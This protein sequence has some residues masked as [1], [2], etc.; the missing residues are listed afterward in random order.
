M[1]LTG[2]LCWSLPSKYTPDI[3]LSMVV[4]FWVAPLPDCIVDGLQLSMQQLSIKSSEWLLHMI[5]V[6]AWADGLTL[7]TD[8]KSFEVQTLCNT[9]VTTTI[10]LI[11]LG[12]SI[13]KRLKW[14][15]FLII[16][17]IA[18]PQALVLD[19]LRISTLVLLK[20][21]TL[22]KSGASAFALPDVSSTIVVVAIALVWIEISLIQ[23]FRLKRIHD[24]KEYN[25]TFLNKLSEHPPFWNNIARHKAAILPSSILITLLGWLTLNNNPAHHAAM[26]KPV[27]STLYNSDNL[28]TAQRAADQIC[29]LTP[30]DNAWRIHTARILLARTKFQEALDSIACMPDCDEKI[31]TQTLILKIR[32]YIGLNEIDQATE[33]MAMIPEEE[34]QKDPIIAMAM[35]KA[36]KLIGNPEQV[37]KYIIPAR[38]SRQNIEGIRSLFP[39]L[40]SLKKWQTINNS[41]ISGIAYTNLDYALVAIDAAMHLND[42]LR[43]SDITLQ[44]I[45]DWPDDP[46]LLK[47]L[48]FLA[49]NSNENR[50]QNHYAEHLRR[51]INIMNDPDNLYRLMS[52]CFDMVRPDLAWM[53]YRRIE[54]IDPQHP[55]LLLAGI[56]Y[57]DKWFVFRSKFLGINSTADNDTTDV[58]MFYTL[59]MNFPSGINS[60]Q[61]IPFGRELSSAHTP[62]ARQQFSRNLLDRLAALDSSGRLSDIMHY[63]YIHSLIET[64]DID[65]AYDKLSQKA[66]AGNE[67]MNY[68]LLSEIYERNADW[69]NVYETLYNIDQ[70]TLPALL[71]L[72]RAQQKVQLGLAAIQTARKAVAIYPESTSAVI[73]LASILMEFDSPEEALLILNQPHPFVN[74]DLNIL[75]SRALFETERFIRTTAFCRE[76][77][78]PPIPVPAGT[79]QSLTLPYAENTLRYNP[80][81]IS[82][83]KLFILQLDAMNAN[84]HTIK[85]PFLNKLLTQ[86]RDDYRAQTA[87]G[88]HAAP[89]SSSG[90]P[91]PDNKTM[92][93]EWTAI[94]RNDTEKAVSLHQSALLSCQRNNLQ[95]AREAI[96]SAINYMPGSAILWRLFIRLSKGD[97]DVIAKARLA[98]PDDSEIWLAELV[99]DLKHPDPEKKEAILTA[100]TPEAL[101]RA[102]AYML[103]TNRPKEACNMA[104]EAVSRADSLLPAYATGLSCATT[105]ND[106]AWALECVRG[107]INSAI[108]P[109]AYFYETLI[110]LK[111]R[112]GNIDSDAETLNA[113]H[114]MHSL[115]PKN[116]HWIE[117]L[118]YAYFKRGGGDMVDALYH[119]S[120]AIDMGS[121]NKSVYILAGEAACQLGN[122]QRASHVLKIAYEKYPKDL[123]LL[124]QLTYVLSLNPDKT[125]EA[126]KYLSNLPAQDNYDLDVMDKIASVHLNCG[127]LDQSERISCEVLD[128]VEKYS[129]L[130]FRS[131]LRIADISVRRKNTAKAYTILTQILP[132]PDN[133][134]AQE[135]AFANNLLEKCR[136]IMEEEKK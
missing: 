82:T 53:I 134:P 16:M 34:R 5:N 30:D 130:W 63:E 41:D 109:L 99:S 84:P 92:I 95:A 126:M 129:I 40:S 83:S 43:I 25:T 54:V 39:F 58:G 11:S 48:F 64:G 91:M 128:H 38:R 85:C 56:N 15:E 120:S 86:Y 113:L 9:M 114:N 136:I 12:L 100:Y 131:N 81:D 103:R 57:R 66:V 73:M 87:E 2:C 14:Y 116:P 20:H 110:N 108:A 44:A 78:I 49:I 31:D 98:C 8:T 125:E 132:H 65:K 94:G 3:L 55:S 117:M 1:I 102:S 135:A 36:G 79:V 70:P 62:E 27:A 93:S 89:S 26:I 97:P 90:A 50:W 35:A 59:A 101:T 4:W 7:R 118:G 133:V 46:R 67:I 88:S 96:A 6:S 18:I 121:T 51:C 42:T 24:K 76:N 17:F 112:D 60:I 28:E 23:R 68:Q 115:E 124:T 106:T 32:A 74:R 47:S 111:C 37:V 119:L 122:I 77:K 71:R 61:K 33:I 123:T 45:S 13:L 72:C 52:D 10:L 80:T 22:G 104:R 127:K 105:N 107:A 75:E 21:F 29:R 19:T 69:Q